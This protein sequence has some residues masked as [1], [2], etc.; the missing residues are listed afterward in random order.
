MSSNQREALIRQVLEEAWN[1]GNFDELDEL[2][3]PDYVQHNPPKDDLVGLDARK[4]FFA[5]YRTAFPDLEISIEEIIMESDT[6][7]V[8]LTWKGTFKGEIPG[9]DA[10]PTGD[11]VR[12]TGQMFMHFKDGKVV[13]Q[14]NQDDYLGMYQQFGYKLVSP[15]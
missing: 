4:K 15:R 5:L 11:L 10:K 8:R 9:L 3:A 2:Y 14:F 6:A 7:A 13:E 12:G 1:R